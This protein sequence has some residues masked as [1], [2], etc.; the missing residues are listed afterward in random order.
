MKKFYSAA[1]SLCSI[2]IGLEL[3]SPN[4]A[5]AQGPQLPQTTPTQQQLE[6]PLPIAPPPRTTVAHCPP[7]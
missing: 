3:F 4:G 6:P 2:G 5:I 1:I 7:P